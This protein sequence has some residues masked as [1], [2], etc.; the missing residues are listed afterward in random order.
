[1][2]WDKNWIFSNT[3]KTTSCG[4]FSSLEH[5]SSCI[6]PS[7]VQ[8]TWETFSEACRQLPPTARSRM[9]GS[10]QLPFL[11]LTL[12]Q[13]S[14]C[15]LFSSCFSSPSPTFPH[16]CPDGRNSGQVNPARHKSLPGWERSKEKRR[17]SLTQVPPQKL[18]QGQGI[19]GPTALLQHSPATHLATPR[20]PC[21]LS[22]QLEGHQSSIRPKQ[23][24]KELLWVQWWKSHSRMKEAKS[25][26]AN[27]S[28]HERVCSHIGVCI[29]NTSLSFHQFQIRKHPKDGDSMLNLLLSTTINSFS[30][31]FKTQ[32][33]QVST[34]KRMK[35][36]QILICCI[37]VCSTKAVAVPTTIPFFLKTHWSH[38]A[39]LLSAKDGTPSATSF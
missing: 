26:W 33:Y 15:S 18:C 7:S 20:T 27:Y 8:K 13:S 30:R 16:A 2:Q 22:L 6:L 19:S 12:C 37:I 21:V 1:M 34:R 39:T 29:F 31:L 5:I 36:V 4:S 25:R 10:T 28:M 9:P 38:I 14:S 11:S 3:C 23:R 24:S 32:L 17:K 35:I